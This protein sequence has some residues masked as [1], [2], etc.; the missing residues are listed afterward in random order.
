[1]NYTCAEKE[2]IQLEDGILVQK[3]ENVKTLAMQYEIIITIQNPTMPKEIL[4]IIEHLRE[5]VSKIL[6][7]HTLNLDDRKN[8]LKRLDILKIKVSTND[9]SITSKRQK[10]TLFGFIRK[11]SKSLFGNASEEDIQRITAIIRE[12]R[13]YNNKIINH[14]NGLL[15]IV[16]H[17]NSKI[18][19]YYKRY[20][21]CHQ[22]D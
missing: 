18:Q 20:L 5:K 2:V 10:C 6:T 17:S 19:L 3:E 8:W 4:S 22:T 11:L 13:N 14:V 16:N 7:I 15:S 9:S 1:M 12:N 21:W